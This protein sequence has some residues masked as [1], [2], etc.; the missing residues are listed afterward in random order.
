MGKRGPKG[1]KSTDK[2]RRERGLLYSRIRCVLRAWPV[3]WHETRIE[4]GTF[5]GLDFLVGDAQAGF[6]LRVLYPD[7]IQGRARPDAIL[8]C[9]VADVVR[10]CQRHLR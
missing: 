6:V 10:A 2:R 8:T 1:G 5:G 3:E 7:E 4:A 9:S